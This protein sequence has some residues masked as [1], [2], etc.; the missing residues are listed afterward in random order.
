VSTSFQTP[1]VQPLSVHAD[2]AARERNESSY[3]TTCAVQGLPE[4][5]IAVQATESA[6][7]VSATDMS[8][9]ADWLFVMGGSITTVDLPAGQTVWT[10]HTTTWT[11]SEKYP[12]VAVFV[13]VVQPTGEQVMPEIAAAVTR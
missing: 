11:D 5:H 13:S 7:L 9:I 12:V 4:A 8:V 2:R 1:L 3:R 10:L 6:V